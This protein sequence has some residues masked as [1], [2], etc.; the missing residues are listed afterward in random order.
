MKKLA[1]AVVFLAIAG[2]IFAQDAPKAEKPEGAAPAAPVSGEVKE[3]PAEAPASAAVKEA[4][5]AA[6]GEFCAKVRTVDG[7]ETL[8]K[9]H[10]KG[11]KFFPKGNL[12]CFPTADAAKGAGVLGFCKM[13][14]KEL[15]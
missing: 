1:V 10:K 8:G 5:A 11:C 9:C 15:Q 6:E 12:K 3:A 14:C 13:C 7:K 2:V 4:P